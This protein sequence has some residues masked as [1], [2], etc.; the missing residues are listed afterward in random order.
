MNRV[1]D[2]HR[3]IES[4]FVI[5]EQAMAVLVEA[6]RGLNGGQPLAYQAPVICR[7]MGKLDWRENLP[8]SMIKDGLES[9][10]DYG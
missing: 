1:F 7:E 5:E 3:T 10:G 6:S 9:Q 4:A 8:Y 2:T